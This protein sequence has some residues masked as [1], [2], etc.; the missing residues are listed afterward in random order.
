MKKAPDAKKTVPVSEGAVS[1]AKALETL[2]QLDEGR[3]V[4]AH[5]ARRCGFFES[6][7]LRKGDGEIASMATECKAAQRVIW[8]EL[9]QQLPVA[10]R[11][12]IEEFAEAPVP[13]AAHS[14]EER[15]K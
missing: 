15:K 1:L 4:L 6:G 9:R 8:V 13:V 7:L 3:I 11:H 12:A 10:M 2:A 5:L 14:E